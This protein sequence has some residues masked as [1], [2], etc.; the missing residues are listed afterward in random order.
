[1]G[2]ELAVWVRLKDDAIDSEINEETVDLN[3]YQTQIQNIMSAFTGAR[4]L[5]R[6]IGPF[7]NPSVG[8]KEDDIVLRC[9]FHIDH[10]HASQD[11]K[12]LSCRYIY[13]VESFPTTVTGKVQKFR[14]REITE[15]WLK[16]K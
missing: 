15:G 11:K 2:E 16:N 10:Y 6:K 13:L 4:F 1:M 8:E 9:S 5:Q 12:K 7:Q 14:M 3:I